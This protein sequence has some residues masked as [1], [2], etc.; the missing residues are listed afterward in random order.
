MMS[1]ENCIRLS[2][3]MY[4][5]ITPSVI[6]NRGTALCPETGATAVSI[7]VRKILYHKTLICSNNRNARHQICFQQ[8]KHLLSGAFILTL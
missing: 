4:M 8:Q 3:V 7:G 6:M 1:I 2:N 5:V